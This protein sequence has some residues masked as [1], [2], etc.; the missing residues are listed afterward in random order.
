MLFDQYLFGWNIKVGVE[1]RLYS[2]IIFVCFLKVYTDVT[3]VNYIYDS[4]QEVIK[5]GLAFKLIGYVV[6]RI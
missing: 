2:F 1:I 3:I 6:S 5:R 4:K